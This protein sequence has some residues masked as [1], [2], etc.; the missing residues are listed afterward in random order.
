M[1][2]KNLINRFSA[3][4]QFCPHFSRAAAALGNTLTY[5]VTDFFWSKR[6]QFQL[7]GVKLVQKQGC[8]RAGKY[9]YLLSYR[10]FCSKR[11]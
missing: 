6:G 9:P 4:A 10:L 2:I 5:S 8:Q 1:T 11:G 7:V 3:F